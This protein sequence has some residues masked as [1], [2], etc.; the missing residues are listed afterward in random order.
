[1]KNEYGYLH[2]IMGPMFSGKTSRLINLYELLKVNNEVLTINHTLDNRYGVNKIS[3]HDKR[4]I[5][6]YN[7][8]K[9]RE[10]Y[11]H[12]NLLVSSNIIM[13]NEAQFFE[14]LYEIVIVLIERYKKHVYLCGLDGDYRQRPIG[15]ILDL[16]PFSNNIEKLN[17]MCT[18]CIN[19]S[20]YSKRIS[21]QEG[22]IVVGNDNYVPTCRNCFYKDN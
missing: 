4:E 22:Q 11:D 19:P 6:C 10:I 18:Y 16:I 1:M 5:P 14:D 20:I 3:T 9:L 8:K 7:F 21:K 2:I 13:I 17:G 12:D 15:K